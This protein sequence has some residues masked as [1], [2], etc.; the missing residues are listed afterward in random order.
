M[1]PVR[2]PKP[3]P[4]AFHK[5]RRISDLLLWQIRHF[6][7]VAK[8]KSLKVDREVARDVHTEGGAARFIATV[9][10]TLRSTA[11]AKDSTVVPIVRDRGIGDGKPTSVPAIGTVRR[12]AAATKSKRHQ[13][14]R[15]AAAEP[16]IATRPKKAARVADS[17]AGKK[18]KSGAANANARKAKAGSKSRARTKPRKKS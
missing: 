8:K 1:E 13:P 12:I 5:N 6:Q 3:S 11:P 17:G 18:S 4:N 15:N 2:V 14:T 9:T 10:R 16:A 7:H